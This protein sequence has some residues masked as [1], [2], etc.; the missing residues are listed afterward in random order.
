MQTESDEEQAL[1]HL[2][3]RM[4]DYEPTQRIPLSDAV[5]HL[6]FSPLHAIS[7]PLTADQSP[8]PAPTD[9]NDDVTRMTTESPVTS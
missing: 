6:F 5:N 8:T 1:F 9:E 3:L 4:L 2:I 7:P